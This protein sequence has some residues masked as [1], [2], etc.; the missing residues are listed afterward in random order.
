VIIT[1]GAQIAGHCRIDDHALLS[2]LVGVTQFVRLGKYSFLTAGAFAN[3]D[4]PPFTIAAGHWARPRAINRVALR[5]AGLSETQRANIERATRLILDSSLRVDSVCEQIREHCA[6]D[7]Q[8]DY[9]V[10]FLESSSRGVA[11]R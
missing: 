10:A 4:I 3:K 7:P 8:I 1:N 11:R 9:I 6:Q 5:R 2:G